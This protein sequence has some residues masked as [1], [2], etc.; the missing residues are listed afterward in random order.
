[1]TAGRPE[2]QHDPDVSDSIQSKPGQR[3][4]VGTRKGS[5]PMGLRAGGKNTQAI[6]ELQR[7]IEQCVR[8]EQFEKLEADYKKDKA[9]ISV[10]GTKMK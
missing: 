8:A 2:R 3:S 9:T 1:M 10:F 5:R 7:Q 4:R 6:D